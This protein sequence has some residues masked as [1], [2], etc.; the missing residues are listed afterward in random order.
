METLRDV[1]MYLSSEIRDMG[2]F[3]LLSDGSAIP[4]LAFKLKDSSKYTVFD[5]SE[6]LRGGGWQVP[7]Y[8]LPAN[9]TDTAIMRIVVRE[10]LDRDLAD[11]LLE[12]IR[13]ACNHFD[14]FPP[15]HSSSDSAF[16]H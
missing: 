6:R 11:S 13:D 2:P 8:T 4:V 14:E 5:V 15:S 7:A 9:A 3:E 12:S 10:G 1:A 16:A